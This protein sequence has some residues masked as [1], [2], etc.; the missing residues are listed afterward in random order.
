V[1]K[2]FSDDMPPGRRVLRRDLETGVCAPAQLQKEEAYR[3][4]A[5]I[6]L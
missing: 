6:A 4:S 5:A 1:A 3:F 2:T